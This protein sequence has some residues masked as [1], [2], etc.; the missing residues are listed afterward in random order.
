MQDN[1]PLAVTRVTGTLPKKGSTAQAFSLSGWTSQ[2]GPL[3]ATRR[4]N[5]GAAQSVQE[6]SEFAR[7]MAA[8]LT[9]SS[10]IPESLW[11]TDGWR[12]SCWS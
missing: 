9:L 2:P 1:S 4:T 12:N 6:F 11:S 8:P 5:Q 10:Q 7:R 3:H